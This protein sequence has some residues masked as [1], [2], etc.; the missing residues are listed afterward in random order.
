MLGNILAKY[1]S[2]LQSNG[3][4]G[5]GKNQISNEDF[6]DRINSMKFSSQTYLDQA[7]SIKIVI[8]FNKMGEN[9]S[10]YSTYT[11]FLNNDAELETLLLEQLNT[12]TMPA[13]KK[14]L[15]SNNRKLRLKRSQ[16]SP[17]LSIFHSS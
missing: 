2:H 11:A 14:Y 5:Y 9:H 7:F 15:F 8:Q 10:F 1:N 13:Y 6:G 4:L 16:I 3:N 17:V 12:G